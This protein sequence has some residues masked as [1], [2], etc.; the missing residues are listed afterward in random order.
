MSSAESPST[1]DT[2]LGGA[3][4]AMVL[5]FDVDAESCVLA[6]GT[7]YGS[8]LGALSHQQFGPR[9]GVPRILDVLD[10]YDV[11]ATFFVP[12]RSA[13]DWPDI[14]TTIVERG[15]E[16]AAHSHAHRLLSA[17]TASEEVEDLERSLVSL[18]RLGI[19]PLGHRSPMGSP[20]ERTVRLL[21]E[22]GFLYEST[23]MDD[24]RPYRISLDVGDLVELPISWIGDDFPHYA[25]LP[26]PRLGQSLDPPRIALEV[27]ASEL[28]AMR[29]YGALFILVNH[30]F[31]IGRPSRLEVLRQLIE[32]ALD[33]GD[34]RI[35]T[36]LDLARRVER[37]PGI[38]LVTEPRPHT[39]SNEP[40]QPV[41]DRSTT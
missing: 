21:V 10:E 27:W 3:A 2:W 26:D 38:P 41:G 24:D 29:R 20:S 8:H 13:D 16:V 5:S 17:M 9:V 12:G 40:H 4:A 22:H 31:L 1:D 33:F 7:Q 25:F 37:D 18:Q 15:H 39:S 30:P 14:V 36:A 34:V 35:A 19:V 32:L 28:S 23:R 6:E 11:R